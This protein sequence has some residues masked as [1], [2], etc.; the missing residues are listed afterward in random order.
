MSD[1]FLYTLEEFDIS[2]KIMLPH[3]LYSPMTPQN[4]R[5]V[6]F[7]IQ[8]RKEDEILLISSLAFRESYVIAGLT[9]KQIEYF[10]LHAPKEYKENLM[11]AVSDQDVIND[12]GEIAAMMDQELPGKSDANQ[13]RVRRVFD[14]IRNNQVAFRF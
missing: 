12:I 7:M 6:A 4:K 13:Q 14:Y 9:E 2:R 1:G 5:N 8:S 10:A 3:L 11:E